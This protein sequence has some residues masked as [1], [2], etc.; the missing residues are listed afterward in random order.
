VAPVNSAGDVLEDAH[1]RST[2]GFS[3]YDA[4]GVGRLRVPVPPTHLDGGTALV[5]DVPRPGEHDRAILV[6]ELGVV[7]GFEPRVTGS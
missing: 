7:D 3:D 2:D 4:P 6:E 5:G 1:L